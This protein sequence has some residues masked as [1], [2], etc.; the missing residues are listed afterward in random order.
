M[1]CVRRVSRL[2]GAFFRLA[3]RLRR[4]LEVAEPPPAPAGRQHPPRFVPETF[5]KGAIYLDNR[6]FFTEGWPSG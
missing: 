2:A 5:D 6:G 4:L 3:G 1:T